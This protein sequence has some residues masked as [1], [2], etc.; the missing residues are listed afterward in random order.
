MQFYHATEKFDE[1]G[2]TSS[3]PVTWKESTNK[4]MSAFML[5]PLSAQAI[6]LLMSPSSTHWDKWEKIRCPT[7]CI[8][9]SRLSG[10]RKIGVQ[11]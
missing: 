9:F 3:F 8:F 7:Y 11:Q 6:N 1:W 10:H 4:S 5:T 2:S